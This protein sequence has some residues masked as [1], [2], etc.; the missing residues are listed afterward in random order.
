MI[1]KPMCERSRVMMA[2]V[3]LQ[4]ARED[5][6]SCSSIDSEEFYAEMERSEQALA[7][8]ERELMAK[9]PLSRL[10]QLRRMQEAAIE[11]ED[12][13]RAALLRDELKKLVG[14]E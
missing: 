11:R 1:Q 10:E 6:H 7:E 4:K 9:K 8:L 3:I 14:E 2:L 13:E 12:F 5:I